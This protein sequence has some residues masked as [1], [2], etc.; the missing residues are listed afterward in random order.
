MRITLL[1]Y[2]TKRV[3]EIFTPHVDTCGSDTYPFDKIEQNSPMY[4]KYP[5]DEGSHHA[6]VG[7]HDGNMSFTPQSIGMVLCQDDSRLQLVLELKQE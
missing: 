4:L 7:C 5:K 1:Y 2:F 6:H 3:F